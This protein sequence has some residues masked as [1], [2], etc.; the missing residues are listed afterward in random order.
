M[1]LFSKTIGLLQ[2]KLNDTNSLENLLVANNC[3]AGCYM[4]RPAY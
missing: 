4:K 3:K 1:V 2:Q